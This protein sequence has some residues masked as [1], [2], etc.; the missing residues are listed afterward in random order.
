MAEDVIDLEVYERVLPSSSELRVMEN[1]LATRK[2]LDAY[3]TM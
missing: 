2:A 3:Y 1:T